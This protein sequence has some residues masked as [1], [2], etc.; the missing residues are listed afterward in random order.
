LKRMH[1]RRAPG[2]SVVLVLQDGREEA[3][4]FL[5]DLQA[6]LPIRLE[7]EP[8]PLSRELGLETVPTL[9]LVGP[10]GLIERKIEGFER[11]AVEALG[12]RLGVRPPFFLPEDRAPALRPG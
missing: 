6:D 12:A 4:A 7:Q 5:S 9:F 11:A 1:D 3:R 10:D 8:Y 2:S